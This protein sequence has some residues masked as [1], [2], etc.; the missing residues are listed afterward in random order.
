MNIL[1]VVDGSSHSERT[2]KMLEALRPQASTEVTI[3]TVV[4]VASFL[5]GVTLDIIRA[6]NEVKKKVREEQQQRATELLKDT[7]KSL[8]KLKLETLVRWGNPVEVILE[9]AEKRD[10][11]LVIM[12]AKGLTDALNFRLGSVALKVMKYA[13]AS[14]L[15]VRPRSAAVSQ[16]SRRKSGPAI[17]SRVLL[18]TDGSKFSDMVG[19]FLLELPL[20]RRTEIIV[21]TALQSYL[22]AWMG[23]PTLDLRTNQ[24]LL[25]KLQAAE[26]AEARKITLRVQK[27]FR[28]SGYK[29]ASVVVRGSASECILAAANEYHPDIIAVGSKGLTGLESFLL[30]SVAERVARYADCS[31]FIGRIRNGK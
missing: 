8:G 7:A 28:E 29:T 12:G 15:L 30:G 6:K 2:A 17:V 14:V 26:E 20:P 22:E 3:L 16:K 21:L 23:M 25:A 18:A 27:Q 4:P 24:E 5:G 1:L 11:S 19:Q 31:V 13:K 9:E 10:T